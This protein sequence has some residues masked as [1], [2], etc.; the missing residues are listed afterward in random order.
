[1]VWESLFEGEAFELRLNSG[2]IH[3]C[4][5]LGESK[6]DRSNRPCKGPE[7]VMSLVGVWL[8]KASEVDHA[9][10]GRR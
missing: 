10:W 1:M 7:V 6:V 3:Y 5:I 2:E 4:K 9:E 8:A